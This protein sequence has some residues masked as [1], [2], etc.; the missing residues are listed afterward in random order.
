MCRRGVELLSDYCADR[1]LAWD[2][3]GKLVVA[4][5]DAETVKLRELERRAAANGVPGVAG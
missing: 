2:A 1:G 3:R 5:N 4:R